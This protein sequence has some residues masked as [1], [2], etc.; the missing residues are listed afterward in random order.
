MKTP[1]HVRIFTLCVLCMIMDGFDVQALGYVAPALIREWN[2]AP[3]LLGP[4]F[5]AANFGVLIGQLSFTMLADKIGRRPVLLAGTVFFAVATLVT[6]QVNTMSQLLAIRFIA[7]MGMGSIIPNAT[8]LVGEFSPTRVRI[9]WMTWLSIGFTAGAALGG[10]VAAW[11]IPGFG[12]RSVFYVGGILPLVLSV[13]MFAWLHESPEFVAKRE[14][15]AGLPAIHL[16]RDGRAPATLLLWVVNF[17]NLFNLFSLANW[18]PTVVARAGYAT[19]TAVLVGTML[20]I[21]GTISPFAMT[22]FI[23]RR[24]F[25]PVLTV[26]FAIATVSVAMIG[27]PGLSLALLTAMVFIAGAT[28]VGAQPSLNAMAGSFYPT[29]LR[30]TGVGWALGI[31]RAGS[32]VGPVLAGQFMAL[33][34]TTQDI[35]LALGIPALISMVAVFCL[36]GSMRHVTSLAPIPGDFQGSTHGTARRP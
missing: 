25:V 35:F 29:H 28:V 36:R 3:A 7:G 31:G 5:G 26:T 13:A 15:R 8:A 33:K 11:L 10:F 1:L 32:I 20:Q 12:W 19:S 4:V 23:M 17:M 14:T 22:W 30:S 21:G 24:G 18:L 6:A 2:V 9:A 16:F 34:W 27:Y